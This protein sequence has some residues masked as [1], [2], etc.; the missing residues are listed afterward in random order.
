MK[1]KNNLNLFLIC[2]MI[3]INIRN[4]MIALIKDISVR[5]KIDRNTKARLNIIAN[6]NNIS[7]NKLLQHAIN[8][9][10]QAHPLASTEDIDRWYASRDKKG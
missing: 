7:V 8:D 5:V 2:D 9:V 6:D 1:N 4:E 3:N 10:I